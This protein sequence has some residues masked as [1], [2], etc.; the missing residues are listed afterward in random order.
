MGDSK[1]TKKL[2]VK[3]YYGESELS[4]ILIP[5]LYCKLEA[6]DVR[7]EMLTNEKCRNS[8]NEEKQ[9]EKEHFAEG[10][11]KSER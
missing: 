8:T 11:E 7:Y 2:E 4:D 9:K 1:M 10:E 3:H 6:Y 5:M